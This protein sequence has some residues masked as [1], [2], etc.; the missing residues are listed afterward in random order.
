[1][2]LLAPDQTETGSFH[3][4]WEVENVPPFPAVALRALNTRAGSDASLLE[5]CDLIQTDPTFSG[6]ILRLANSPLIGFP[7]PIISVVQAAMLLGFRHLK[8]L[9]VTI[10][11]KAYLEDVN[12]PP[13][14]SCWRHSL[15]SAIVAERAAAA[16]HLDAD[17]AHTAGIL[18]D[19]GRVAMAASMPYSYALVVERGANEPNDLLQSEREIC[20]IDHCQA[21]LTL[22]NSWGLPAAFLQITSHHHDAHAAWKGGVS[23]V[24]TSCMLADALGCPVVKYR[25]ARSYEEILSAFPEAV[26]HELPANGREFAALVKKQIRE[27]EAV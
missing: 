11:L 17:F 2:K 14:Q 10:G 25:A 15:A 22:V 21:G 20:G 5:L 9:V 6:A 26:R 12:T 27:I 4:R 16:L 1:M 3:E 8:S 24:G 13:L 23:L 18:H 7:K 19:L